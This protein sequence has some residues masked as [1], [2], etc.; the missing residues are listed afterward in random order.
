MDSSVYKKKKTADNNTR[1][2]TYFVFEQLFIK[3]LI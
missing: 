3:K 2:D 1:F